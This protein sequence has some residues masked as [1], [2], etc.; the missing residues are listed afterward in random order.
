MLLSPNPVTT[1]VT[2]E[3][4]EEYDVVY[5]FDHLGR[6]L[7]QRT[8]NQKVRSLNLREL[9]PGIYIIKFEGNDKPHVSRLIKL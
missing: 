7:I 8:I 9:Q 6:K 4:A 5:I 3:G 2:I 1:V